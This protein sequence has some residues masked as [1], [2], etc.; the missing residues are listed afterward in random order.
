MT[1]TENTIR[2]KRAAQAIASVNTYDP[3]TRDGLVDLLTD[4]MHYAD[5]IGL[6]FERAAA[7]ASDHHHAETM[8]KE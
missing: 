5:M 1:T 6:D 2:A 3:D 7:I 4:L 8:G